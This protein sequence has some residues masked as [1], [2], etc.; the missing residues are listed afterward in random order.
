VERAEQTLAGPVAGRVAIGHEPRAVAVAAGLVGDP[1]VLARED[2][3]RAGRLV[4]LRGAVEAG[5]QVTEVVFGQAIADDGLA[6]A[7]DADLPA[8]SLRCKTSV[9]TDTLPRMPW[10]LAL[11]STASNVRRASLAIE[12][13]YSVSHLTGCSERFSKFQQLCN[14]AGYL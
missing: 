1:A 14:H 10:T 9:G 3:L 13:S 5:S 4:D 2:L 11:V 7:P 12:P 8:S 6:V